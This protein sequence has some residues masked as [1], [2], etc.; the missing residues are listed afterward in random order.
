VFGPARGEGWA[1]KMEEEKG[2]NG[3]FILSSFCQFELTQK[4]NFE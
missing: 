3:F 1:M 2:R 4:W